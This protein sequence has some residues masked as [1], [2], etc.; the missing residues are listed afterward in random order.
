MIAQVFLA[1]L[2]S[3]TT[4]LL[5]AGPLHAHSGGLDAYGCHHDRKHGGYH[6]HQ[7]PFAGQAYVSKQEMLNALEALN[8]EPNDHPDWL[9]PHDL[10]DPSKKAPA[11]KAPEAYS[12]LRTSL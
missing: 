3:L 11:E 2:L 5:S 1:L 6:C 10:S 4:V 7:G 8:Q 12:I 9:Q